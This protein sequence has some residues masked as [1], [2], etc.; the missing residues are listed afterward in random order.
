MAAGGNFEIL[1]WVSQTTI[2]ATRQPI[3]FVFGSRKPFIG[4]L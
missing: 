4:L 2:S 3:Q 1:K